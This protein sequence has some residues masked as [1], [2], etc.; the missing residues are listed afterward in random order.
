MQYIKL[1]TLP[2]W[3]LAFAL[4]STFAHAEQQQFSL[5][6]IEQGIDLDGQLSEPHWQ[7]ATLIPLRY[8][9]EPN[10]KGTPP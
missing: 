1:I 8:Q 9:N 2:V 5:A 10:E 7:Q 4:C 6:H 3:I